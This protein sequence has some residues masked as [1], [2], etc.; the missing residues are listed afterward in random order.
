MTAL[1]RYWKNIYLLYSILSLLVA[2]AVFVP[3]FV[4]GT[5]LIWQ[6][7][8]IAQHFP[9]LVDWRVTLRQLLFD[10]IW[11]AQWQWHLGLGADYLQ[12][13][14]YYTLGDIFTYGVA[15]VS[16][17]HVL[18]YYNCSVI[19]RLFLAGLSFLFVARQFIPRAPHWSL[20]PATFS[21]IFFGYTAF[22]A[23]E[24]PFFLNPLIIFPLLIWSLNRLLVTH[25]T[26]LFT[27]IVTWTL[28][29]NFYFAFMM[30]LGALLFWLGYLYAT[31]SWFNWTQHLRLLV[32]TGIGTLMPMVLL[33]PSLISVLDSA[34][35]GKTLANGLTLYPAYYY[36]GLPGNLIANFATPDFWVTGGFSALAVFAVIYALR[37]W[38]EYKTFNWV[39]ILVGVG[40]LLPA[41]AGILNGFSSPSNRWLFMIS[42]PVNLMMIHF[43]QHLRRLTLR[44]YIWFAIVGVIASLSLFIMSDF[45][46]NSRFSPMI[47][48]YAISLLL[49]WSLQHHPT[50]PGLKA[51]LIAVV[52]L[53]VTF[54][55]NRNHTNNTNP[56]TSD[57]LSERSINK[58]LHGQR[59]YLPENTANP[60]FSRVYIDNQL[61]NATGIAPTTNLPILSQT[62]NIESYWSVQNKAV[63]TMMQRLQIAGSSPNDITSNLDNRNIL[64]NV[65]GV[66]TRYQNSSTMT[67]NS[68]EQNA[69]V[70]VNHQTAFTS[71][72]SYPLVYLPKYTVAAKD[73]GPM[74]A[75]E[76]EATLA[77]SV[78]VPG[79]RAGQ[80]SA[81]AKQIVSGV[82]RTDQTKS[83][84]TSLHYHYKTHA[85]LL[86]DGIFLMANKQLRGTELHLEI[87][88]LRYTPATFGQRQQNALAAYQYSATQNARNMQSSPNIRYNP[89]AFTWNWTQ[90]HLDTIGTEY[91]GYKLTANYND[92]DVS[93]SQTG[94]TN[95]SFYNPQNAVT[96]NLGQATDY[97]NEQFIPLTF[98]RDGDYS[99]DVRIVGIP[100]DKR[101]SRVARQIQRTAPKLRF[102]RNQVLTTI[103]VQSPRMLA[104]T[105]P[106][107]T[108][109]S[110][111]GRHLVKI[112]DG[113]IGIP[114]KAGQNHLV[115]TYQTPGLTIGLWLSLLGGVLSSIALVLKLIKRK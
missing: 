93:F 17:D 74:T 96:L 43:L 28:W 94:Q 92:H 25:K 87:S 27:I 35:S 53:N 52:L 56:A 80:S 62:N 111:N 38:H 5:S 81:F 109:W 98:S 4:T 19:V 9:A 13:F 7:D 3:Y 89:K 91:A 29:N 85:S 63:N 113:F 22:A 57:M 71:S 106:Y 68:Y 24:H 83:G 69:N 41:F 102:K 37:H 115:L 67:P 26:F 72:D 55:T 105:I 82:I 45:S 11:P 47:A 20:I 76:K 79:M 70:S 100:T 36:F 84:Q 114:L 16:Q 39:F 30:A 78:V 31:R 10:H 54:I 77:D 23:F 112:N 58:L 34:R 44:D 51:L 48:L 1:K 6:S 66:K 8:G 88:N 64:M 60:S 33:L 104:T 108:G 61:G 50:Q 73:Y 59:D 103:R 95:L 110:A 2:A 12:T 21:Y 65:L 14:S 90:H 86:P 18:A 97:K 101:F 49:I 40:L 99:F 15:F 107:S 32:A 75:T 42:L 46:L